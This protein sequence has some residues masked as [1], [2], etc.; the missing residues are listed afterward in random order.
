MGASQEQVRQVFE[1]FTTGNAGEP[2]MLKR[3]HLAAL[4]RH[5]Y[6]A[7]FSEDEIERALD[8]AGVPQEGDVSFTTFVNWLYAGGGAALKSDIARAD[9]RGPDAVTCQRLESS[10]DAGQA[11]NTS[12]AAL[13]IDSQVRLTAESPCDA[14][15]E[16][17]R[18][19]EEE[20][21][22]KAKIK[23]ELRNL[24]ATIMSWCAR[25]KENASGN[26]MST[27]MG[28]AVAMETA[29]SGAC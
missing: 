8:L 9:V 28:T 13:T 1:R 18:A 29:V 21:L 6:G 16:D 22:K 11:T 7:A 5:V 4:M 15:Q 14:K 26:G 19:E 12:H 20:E 25:G 17:D 27:R 23:D 2:R 3:E 24:A 10:E